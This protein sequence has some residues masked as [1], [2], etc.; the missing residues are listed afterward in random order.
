MTLTLTLTVTVTL[1]ITVTLTMTLTLSM[2]VTVTVTMT[3]T[4]TVTVTMTMTLTVTVTM[5]LT[6]TLAMTV[7]LTLATQV[8]LWLQR[9]SLLH[10]LYVDLHSGSISDAPASDNNV[11]ISINLGLVEVPFCDSVGETS[12]I[13]HPHDC[14]TFQDKFLRINCLEYADKVIRDG[15]NEPR[16]TDGV[17]VRVGQLCLELLEHCGQ[18]FSFSDC[19]FINIH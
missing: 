6:L 9:Q 17:G 12:V 8:L 4:V 18:F 5:T 16:I 3:M 1:T 13:G 19:E 11:L 2:T 10:H 14:A 7:T 15:T